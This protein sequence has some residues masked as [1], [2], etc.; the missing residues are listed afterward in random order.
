MNISDTL[1]LDRW[2]LYDAP[3]CF[4]VVPTP[5]T[6]LP[7]MLM[8]ILPSDRHLWVTSVFNIKMKFPENSA[9]LKLD[10]ALTSLCF[11]FFG[12]TYR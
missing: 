4:M 10:H 8:L 2:L 9:K 7:Q 6:P 1:F 12:S 3:V 5:P 11:H